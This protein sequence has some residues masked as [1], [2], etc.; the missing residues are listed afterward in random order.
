MMINENKRKKDMN[1]SK[2]QVGNV[3][4]FAYAK[5]NNTPVQERMCAIESVKTGYNVL[6]G[7]V[8]THITGYD[9]TVHG[10]RTFIVSKILPIIKD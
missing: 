3:I 6:L 9:D 5:D 8:P 10:Y 2:Y 4:R 1:A 7:R